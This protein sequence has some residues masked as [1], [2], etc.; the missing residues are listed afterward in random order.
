LKEIWILNA[1]QN[2]GWVL[3]RAE[4]CGE[5]EQAPSNQVDKLI[6]R[7]SADVFIFESR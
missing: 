4:K 6:F 5:I 2:Q 1:N 7:H 3:I